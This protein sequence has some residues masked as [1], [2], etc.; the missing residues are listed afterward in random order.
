MCA[1][2]FTHSDTRFAAAMRRPATLTQ[3]TLRRDDATPQAKCPRPR[4]DSED[5]LPCSSWMLPSIRVSVNAMSKIRPLCEN[6]KS[7][8]EAWLSRNWQP[9]KR[10][11]SRSYFQLSHR[12]EVRS[13]ASPDCFIAIAV[14]VEGKPNTHQKQNTHTHTIVILTLLFAVVACFG[15]LHNRCSHKE[16]TAGVVQ[17]ARHAH[18]PRRGSASESNFN[19]AFP[20]HKK[21]HTTQLRSG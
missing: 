14:V 18:L 20:R 21:L 19:F 11:A 5:S 15:S 13:N 4:F 9:D 8:S 12:K 1:N 7:S 3:T 6:E 2:L 16:A 17:S 10:H